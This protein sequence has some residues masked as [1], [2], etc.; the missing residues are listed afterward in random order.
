MAGHVR[1][2]GS[3]RR[4]ANLLRARRG[5]R[6][7]RSMRTVAELGLS[8]IPDSTLRRALGG[9]PLSIWCRVANVFGSTSRSPRYHLGAKAKIRIRSQVPEIAFRNWFSCTR[10]IKECGSRIDA[11][12][13]DEPTR[14]YLTQEYHQATG[15][16]LREMGISEV[17]FVVTGAPDVRGTGHGGA[18]ELSPIGHL[19]FGDGAPA[20]SSLEV[21]D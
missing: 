10:Q 8:H 16:A 11:A 18:G 6:G 21:P 19:D 3:D 13:P 17:R 2:P 15:A 1:R 20:R 12:V 5:S 14:A 4:G 7:C 9:R